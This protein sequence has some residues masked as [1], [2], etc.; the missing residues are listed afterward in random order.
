MTP[1]DCLIALR[2]RCHVW[3]SSRS[4][5]FRRIAVLS[6][7][8]LRIGPYCLIKLAKMGEAIVMTFQTEALGGRKV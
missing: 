2:I 1:P 3:E 7:V 8:Q 4:L 6:G 5:L